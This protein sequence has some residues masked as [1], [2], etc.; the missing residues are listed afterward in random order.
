MYGWALAYS[1]G[2]LAAVAGL[3]YAMTTEVFVVRLNSGIWWFAVCMAAILALLNLYYIL[4]PTGPLT[5][6]ALGLALI[7]LFAATVYLGLEFQPFKN[8]Q[9]S[10]RARAFFLPDQKGNAFYDLDSLPEPED[11]VV[12]TMPPVLNQGS[13]GS[14]WAYAGALVIA[15]GSLVPGRPEQESCIK[16]EGFVQDWVASPQSL[17]D[18]SNS[19]CSGDLTT[20]ALDLAASNPLPTLWCIPGYSAFEGNCY[21]G[22]GSPD[23][24]LCTLPDNRKKHLTCADGSVVQNNSYSDIKYQRL[25]GERQI[26]Q[27][28]STGNAVLAWFADYQPSGSPPHPFWSLIDNKGNRV[29]IN[30]RVVVRPSDEGEE[31]ELNMGPIRSNTTGAYGHLMVIFGYGESDGVKYWNVQNSWGKNWGD[32]GRIKV[33]RGIDAWG[34]ETRSSW[35]VVRG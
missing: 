28:L 16:S 10:E 18:F 2:Y 5:K 24:P 22:C 17:I 13:C 33:E 1:C 14:C 11:E 15:Q 21:D 8:I 7:G 27:W 12:L 4:Q 26:M 20:K 32:G 25:S 35:G 23:T 30:N 29:V 9:I 31:Y 3:F 34:C 6:A 19:K